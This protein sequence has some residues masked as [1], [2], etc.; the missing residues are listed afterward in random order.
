MGRLK[1]QQCL[2]GSE[3]SM[4]VSH[5]HH[6]HHHHHGEN[7]R[8]HWFQGDKAAG[9]ETSWKPPAP[10][11]ERGF[12]RGGKDPDERLGTHLKVYSKEVEGR[13][14]VTSRLGEEAASM[15]TSRSQAWIAACSLRL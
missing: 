7:L 2:T 6:H 9:W 10:K 15:P 14:S 8:A 3:H 12:N 5:C 11:S 1:S 4:N 13:M